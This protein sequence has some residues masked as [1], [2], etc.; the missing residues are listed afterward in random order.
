[1]LGAVQFAQPDDDKRE[2]ECS[3]Q[4]CI[5]R[6]MGFTKTRLDDHQDAEKTD[7]HRDDP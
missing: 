1:M 3:A 5:D 4:S 2:E 7:D 6:S